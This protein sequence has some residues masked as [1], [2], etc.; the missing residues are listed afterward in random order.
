M[1]WNDERKY[2]DPEEKVKCERPFFMRFVTRMHLCGKSTDP[3]AFH[4]ENSAHFHDVTN[5]HHHI[6]R[7]LG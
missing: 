1:E 4:V 5:P 2:Q 6:L 3:F 7:R